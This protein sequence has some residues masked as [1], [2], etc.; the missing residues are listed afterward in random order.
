[1]GQGPR[2]R[3]GPHRLA[4][5]PRP[6]RG[7]SRV[8]SPGRR[9]VRRWPSSATSSSHWHG[10]EPCQVLRAS[11]AGPGIFTRWQDRCSKTRR[12]F[13][14]E[15][16]MFSSSPCDTGAAFTPPL[17]TLGP[18]TA[19]ASGPT[20][21]AP[22]RPPLPVMSLCSLSPQG[23][24]LGSAG[25]G[26]LWPRGGEGGHR[27]HIGGGKPNSG[28][29]SP[30]PCSHRGHRQELSPSLTLAAGQR[31]HTCGDGDD[32][33]PS[34]ALAAPVPGSS[35]PPQPRRACLQH[36]QNIA[37]AVTGLKIA[38]QQSATTFPKSHVVRVR[39]LIGNA[40]FDLQSDWI[41]PGHFERKKV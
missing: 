27:R 7:T 17:T 37:R 11:Q 21:H 18:G 1:M 9:E 5:C 41:F 23:R 29:L 16:L 10:W 15:G 33:P 13:Q 14:G 25:V 38:S 40:Y 31:L 35:R 24:C 19:P 20:D 4:G 8:L 28:S 39:G 22:S 6:P 26:T 32:V 3:S 12:V 2:G 34:P 30:R 36:A